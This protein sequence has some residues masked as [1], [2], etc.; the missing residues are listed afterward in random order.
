M[1]KNLN[2]ATSGK[3]GNDTYNNLSDNNTNICDT[4]GRLY[5]WAIAKDVCPSGWHLPSKEEWDI[6]LNFAGSSTVAKL[7]A[8]S[9]SGTNEYGFS[10]LPGSY[11]ASS[12]YFNSSEI[13]NVGYWWSSTAHINNNAYGLDLRDYA[14]W[15]EQPNNNMY[16]VRCVRN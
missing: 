13:G 8:T 16:S 12:G 2:Y 1:A 9:W 11:G 5:T 3:C 6:L 7:K 4:Y 10:A 14:G 15:S